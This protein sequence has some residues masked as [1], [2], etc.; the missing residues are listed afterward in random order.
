MLQFDETVEEESSQSRNLKLIATNFNQF[1]TN[2]CI[3]HFSSKIPEYLTKIFQELNLSES[4][5]KEI[6]KNKR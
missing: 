5:I 3:N 6:Q 2:Y 4:L 1:V